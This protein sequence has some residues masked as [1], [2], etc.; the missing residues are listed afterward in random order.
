MLGDVDCFG[1]RV[2]SIRIETRRQ[3]LIEVVT[4]RRDAES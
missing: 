1:Q 2:D 4:R 3:Q